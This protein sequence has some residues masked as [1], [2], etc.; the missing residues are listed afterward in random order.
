MVINVHKKAI[1]VIPVF[2]KYQL[3]CLSL[4]VNKT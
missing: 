1:K 3:L 4:C 2:P